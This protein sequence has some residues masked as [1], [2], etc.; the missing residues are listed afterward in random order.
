MLT[1]LEQI[2]RIGSRDDLAATLQRLRGESPRAGRAT[3]LAVDKIV[4]LTG[5]PR[6]TLYTYL[7]GQSLPSLEALGVLGSALGATPVERK[8]LA[9]AWNRLTGTP[10]ATSRDAKT[11][12]ELTAQ[13]LDPETAALLQPDDRIRAIGISDIYV[14]DDGGRL[15]RA[16]ASLTYQA[17]DDGA[18]GNYA[19]IWPNAGVAAD[20]IRFVDAINCRLDVVEHAAADSI[21]VYRTVFGRPLA[22]G[23][24]TTM[25]YT[26]DYS[27]AYGPRPPTATSGSTESQGRNVRDGLTHFEVMVQFHP[28]LVPAQVWQVHSSEPNG[29]VLNRNPVPVNALGVAELVLRNVQPG[30]H[31]LQWDW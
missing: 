23:Q 29:P 4:G 8:A 3:K 10:Q 25:R 30:A 7:K 14:F 11:L 26:T 6:S 17:Q 18:D 15:I 12:T 5:I 27:D 13:R 28:D 24:T 31:G 1:R 21:L 22:A 16:H 2:E 20:R 19:V 9:R